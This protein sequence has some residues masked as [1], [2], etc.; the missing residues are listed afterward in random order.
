MRMTALV[1]LVLFPF[2]AAVVLG[3]VGSNRTWAAH[4]RR[5]QERTAAM[6]EAADLERERLEAAD[7]RLLASQ[8]RLRGEDA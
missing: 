7:A 8:R 4:Y 6:A 3:W 5:A 1:L 2:V